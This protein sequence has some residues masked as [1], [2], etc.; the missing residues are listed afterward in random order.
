MPHELIP[1]DPG[2][3]ALEAAL[4]AL[5]PARASLDRDR[6]MFLAGRASALASAPP[7]P[8]S[9]RSW[10]GIAACLAAVAAGEAMLLAGRPAGRVVEK[11]VVIR[12]PAPARA[13]EA[14]PPTT[15]AAAGANVAILAEDPFR[16]GQTPR[17]RLAWQVLRYGL[18]GLPAPPS[19]ARDPSMPDPA[20]AR[21]LLREELRNLLDPGGP[22]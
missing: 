22:S 18:D 2:L 11:V 5:A 4:G 10:I 19:G 16:P 17:D 12:E 8:P 3:D 15:L 9:R 21:E 20:P 13:A 7:S 6:T 1:P 14:D